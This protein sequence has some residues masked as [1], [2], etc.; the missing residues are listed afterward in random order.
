MS[1]KAGQIITTCSRRFVT[2]NGGEKE[3]NPSKLPLIQVRSHF[4]SRILA[5][6]VPWFKSLQRLAL[7]PM[8]TSLQPALTS[9]DSCNC[10]RGTFSFEQP[11]NRSRGGRVRSHSDW[12]QDWFGPQ[13]SCVELD[14]T[15]IIE[16]Q[17]TLARLEPRL[18][19]VEAQQERMLC[20]LENITMC[21]VSWS[22]FVDWVL[23]FNMSAGPACFRA[24]RDEL[25]FDV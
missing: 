8:M 11:D 9:F 25:G 14:K 7:L 6:M 4:G 5:Q 1:I 13:I 22:S 18:A 2:P 21:L 16:E 3:G 10:T 23:R 20:L 24:M 19:R 15:V 17:L 12:G